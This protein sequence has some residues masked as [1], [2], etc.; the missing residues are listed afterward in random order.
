M[1][2]NASSPIQRR[3]ARRSWLVEYLTVAY[4]VLVAYAS[5]YPFSPWWQLASS[6]FAFLFEAWPR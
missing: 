3:F 2:T 6:P 4:T 5:L 1:D